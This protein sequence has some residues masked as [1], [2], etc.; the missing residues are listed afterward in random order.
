MLEPREYQQRALDAALPH[1]GFA[2]F[3]E[4][5]TGKTLK[6]LW[7]AQKWDCRD[8]LIICPKKAI[9]VWKSE[10]LNAGGNPD[11][12]EVVSFESFRIHKGEYRKDWDLVV[13][14][15]SH[16]IKSRGSQQTKAVWT[17]SRRAR[18]R[19]I[20]SGSPQ[21]SGCEDYYA[22]LK[23]IRPDLFPTWGEFSD[24]FLIIKDR[25]IAGREDP[26]PE[27]VGY[28]NQE[29][30]KELLASIS[31]RVTRDEVSKVKT[32]VRNKKYSIPWSEE[33]R[34][35]YDTLDE[36]LYIEVQENIVSAAHVLV[37]GI[38]LHQL[39]GG[40]IK[41]DDKQLHQ[42]GT[43][44]LDFLWGLIDGPLAGK[45]M[46]IVAQYKAEMDAIAEGL[47]GRGISHVQVRGK[48][49]Y[50]PKD[51][52]QVTI[53]HPSSGEAINLAHHNH[54]VIYSMGY[55]FLKWT[56]FKDRIVLV[57]TPQVTYHYLLMENSMVEGYFYCQNL[58]GEFIISVPY[59]FVNG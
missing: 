18:K 53:L 50:N 8:N 16:R 52:S 21:D 27:V 28:K 24:Q 35:L 7:L 46:V 57:D 2:L 13:V 26:F 59:L 9:P 55:S 23:F 43:D 25:W 56:Q 19:I 5:R 38:K 54:M 51:R 42:L 6:A 17:L 30:F 31:F 12:F 15:E 58:A 4:Q 11:E 10:I 40:F 47:R 32:L 29:Y 49:Q 1:D 3:M 33:A 39:C 20:L 48:H 37:E 45:S 34:K 41:D 14:D 36:K 22:Q 44:K